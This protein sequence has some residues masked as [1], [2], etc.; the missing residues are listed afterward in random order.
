M[1]LKS[2]ISL[3]IA[4]VG[5]VL[6]ACLVGTGLCGTAWFPFQNAAAEACLT[7]RGGALL[8]SLEGV[9]ETVVTSTTFER[10][11]VGTA[12]ERARLFAWALLSAAHSGD[13]LAAPLAWWLANDDGCF[14][15]WCFPAGEFFLEKKEAGTNTRSV[16][17]ITHLC[18]RLVHLRPHSIT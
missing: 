15:V 12:V 13:L 4:P 17:S 1:T 16:K 2:F 5:P 10:L 14:L 6:L 18:Y 3:S 9:T 7:E 11:V 8:Y